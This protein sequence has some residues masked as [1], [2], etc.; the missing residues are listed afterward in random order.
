MTIHKRNHKCREYSGNG[1]TEKEN[2]ERRH[3]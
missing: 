2:V 1:C 3:A